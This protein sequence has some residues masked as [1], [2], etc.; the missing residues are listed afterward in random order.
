MTVFGNI[1]ESE[2]PILLCIKRS[3]DIKMSECSTGYMFQSNQRHVMECSV[4][5]ISCLIIQSMGLSDIFP[6]VIYV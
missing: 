3:V 1:A 6:L 5:S 4:P 2:T